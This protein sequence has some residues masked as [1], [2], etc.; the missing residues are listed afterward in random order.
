MI[1]SLTIPSLMLPKTKTSQ[2][3]LK[4]GRFFT[5]N[6][7]TKYDF[8]SRNVL[9]D[10]GCILYIVSYK[11]FYQWYMKRT[12][13]RK[14]FMLLFKPTFIFANF[15]SLIVGRFYCDVYPRFFYSTKVLLTQESGLI[16]TIL[17]V[18]GTH[19]QGSPELLMVVC[20]VL[21][22]V[23][24]FAAPLRNNIFLYQATLHKRNIYTFKN[25]INYLSFIIH[26]FQ[27]KCPWK[28][29]S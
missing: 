1:I 19:S 17:I 16:S 7:S 3:L 18:D 4:M 27:K 10:P 23:F 6:R 29:Y 28:I 15:G 9:F 25:K 5:I 20:F 24:C 2:K 14:T 26:Q 11:M 21:F 13:L 22:N 12:L 8:L